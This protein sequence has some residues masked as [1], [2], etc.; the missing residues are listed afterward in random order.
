SEVFDDIL[1]VSR[2]RLSQDGTAGSRN[3]AVVSAA[4]VAGIACAL[5]LPRYERSANVAR[6]L[7]VTRA[8]VSLYAAKF[9]RMLGTTSEQS[10]R[11][12]GGGIMA[13]ARVKAGLK[14]KVG[15]VVHAFSV[16]DREPEEVKV[17]LESLPE[18]EREEARKAL[19]GKVA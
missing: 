14:P 12:Q 3:G 7:R 9:G 13:M 5:S 8:G 2:K 16:G 11:K 10:A 6:S 19:R 4:M 17:W 18:E 15:P 1:R